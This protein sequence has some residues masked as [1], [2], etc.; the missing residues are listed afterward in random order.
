MLI[1]LPAHQQSIIIL[2][3]ITMGSGMVSLEMSDSTLY[4][5][6]TQPSFPQTHNLWLYINVMII[7]FSY[8]DLIMSLPFN[9]KEEK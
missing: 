8:F 4:Q 2:F 6:Q 9:G 5:K 1:F 3:A 7:L